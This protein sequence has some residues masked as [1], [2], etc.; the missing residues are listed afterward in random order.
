MGLFSF[1]GD[2]AS[3]TVKIAVTP[4][5]VSK[6][7]ISIATDQEADATKNLLSSA[8]DDLEQSL[9]DLLED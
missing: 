5:A 3:A 4:L 6:D 2:V 7:I 9:D 1:I 8:G